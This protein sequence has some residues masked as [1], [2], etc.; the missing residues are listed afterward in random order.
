LR[1]PF[2]IGI[3]QRSKTRARIY[4]NRRPLQIVQHCLLQSCLEN[5]DRLKVLL[6]VKNLRHENRPFGL[7]LPLGLLG[8]SPMFYVFEQRKA[9]PDVGQDK[10]KAVRSRIARISSFLEVAA[11]PG[12]RSFATSPPLVQRRFSFS[13]VFWKQNT[14]I[15]CLYLQRRSA[16]FGYR[17]Q[18]TYV[19]LPGTQSTCRELHSL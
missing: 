16:K 1:V 8:V 6:V 19:K 14:V 10:E 13:R 9:L 11:F 3:D 15:E 12:C 18:S 2:Q 17:S 7:L 5:V 4:H